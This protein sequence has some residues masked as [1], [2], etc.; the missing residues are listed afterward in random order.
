M[1]TSV[2]R[3]QRL[4][5]ARSL[6]ALACPGCGIPLERVTLLATHVRRCDKRL[7][8]EQDRLEAAMEAQ[9]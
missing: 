6:P 3:R 7:A 4:A 9:A 1:S 2:K 8:A 5:I